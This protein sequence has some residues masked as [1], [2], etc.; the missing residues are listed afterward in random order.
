MD[1]PTQSRLAHAQGER[2]SGTAAFTRSEKADRPTPT[3]PGPE[4]SAAL[5]DRLLVDLGQLQ[6]ADE[7]AD[8]VHKNLAAKNT[9]APTDAELV[10]TAFLG[11]LAAIEGGQMDAASSQAVDSPSDEPPRGQSQALDALDA[12]P[13]AMTTLRRRR[14]AAKTIRLRDRSTANSSPRSRAS[15]VAARRPRRIT[16]GSRNR[17]R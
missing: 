7:A 9:L 11:T 2:P 16:F 12:A 1:V 10:E 3:I 14:V 5:R 6:S 15:Y 4:L 8:W 13:P 17:P